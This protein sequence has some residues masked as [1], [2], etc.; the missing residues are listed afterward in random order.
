M[1]PC[2]Y[3][4]NT[5]SLCDFMKLVQTFPQSISFFRNGKILPKR[6]RNASETV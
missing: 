3:C 1:M 5:P 2:K 6:F 4:K